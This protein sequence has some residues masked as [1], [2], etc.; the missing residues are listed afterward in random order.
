MEKIEK[1]LKKK[2]KKRFVLLL[3]ELEKR[4]ATLTTKEAWRYMEIV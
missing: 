2:K 4:I 1:K 3:I